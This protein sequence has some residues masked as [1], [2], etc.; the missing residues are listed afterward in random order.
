MSHSPPYQA[1][2]YRSKPSDFMPTVE[3]SA[4][5]CECDG[6]YLLLKHAA[7]KPQEN[8]WGV[9][10][11]KLEEGEYPHAAVLRE[12][13][14]EV[15]IPLDKDKVQDVGKLFVRY[16]HIDFVYHMFYQHFSELPA[17]H[18]SD[19]HEEFR[20]VTFEEAFEM[21]LISGAKEAIHHFQAL[22][23][24]PKLKRKSFYFIRHGE[25]DANLKFVKG[26]DYDLPLNTKGKSQALSARNLVATLPLK[27]VC[28]ST[29]QRAVETKN[30]VAAD[31]GLNHFEIEKLKECSADVWEK[32]VCLEKGK[33][34]HVCEDVGDF[35]ARSIEGINI[36][37]EHEGPTL[38]VAHGGIHWAL[39]YTM[40]I[41]DHRW[42]LG[43]CELLQFNP[44]GDSEW[45][46]RILYQ[47]TP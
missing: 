36:A 24:K 26:I 7:G 20:W 38:I 29:M 35:L 44:V 45:E 32:M 15:G 42:R 34:Y 39:C 25:T 3:V 17:V 28:S 12:T 6:K 43:N 40:M 31:L 21:P 47:E 22:A 37:L 23:K 41:E 8:T 9:P 13:L 5:Y 18:L 33:D 14:E 27:T 30:L 10:A 4:C 1:F 16:P 11:G 46:A 19:E 2:V